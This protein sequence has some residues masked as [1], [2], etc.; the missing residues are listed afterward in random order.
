M[1]QET[2]KVKIMTRLRAVNPGHSIMGAAIHG[3]AKHDFNADS[4]IEMIQS[5]Y[6]DNPTGMTEVVGGAAMRLILKYNLSESCKH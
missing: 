2:L 1:N 5:Q 3:A 6:S 4:L